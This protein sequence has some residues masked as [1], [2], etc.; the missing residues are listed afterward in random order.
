L[1]AFHPLSCNCDSSNCNWIMSSCNRIDLSCNLFVSCCHL[2]LRDPFPCFFRAKYL[3]SSFALITYGRTHP[4]Y[5]GITVQVFCPS[6]Y[7][8]HW[9]AWR[10]RRR[11]GPWPPAAKAASMHVLWKMKREAVLH[12]GD[13]HRGQEQAVCALNNSNGS[14]LS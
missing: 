14:S 3:T 2:Q 11:N 6:T 10:A 8:S 9:R 7:L 12:R 13:Q 1:N 4:F 5:F